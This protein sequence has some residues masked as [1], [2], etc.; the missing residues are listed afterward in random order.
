MLQEVGTGLAGQAVRHRVSL[1]E[2]G[3]SRHLSSGRRINGDAQ[4]RILVDNGQM[5]GGVYGLRNAPGVTLKPASEWSA[6]LS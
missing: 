2:P 5:R 1:N 4:H 6:L 3:T